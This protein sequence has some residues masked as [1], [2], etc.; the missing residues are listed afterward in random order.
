[1]EGLPRAPLAT[2]FAPA[3]R[4]NHP[5]WTRRPPADTGL[6]PLSSTSIRPVHLELPTQMNDLDSG[7]C[8]LASHDDGQ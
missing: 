3:F 2:R 8:E 6:H 1:M 5:A 7:H 4:Y